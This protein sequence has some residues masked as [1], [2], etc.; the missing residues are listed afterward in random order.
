MSSYLLKFMGIDLAGK[1]EKPT[2]W[3]VIDNNLSLW[4]SF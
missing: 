3:A 4:R 1:E 2:G